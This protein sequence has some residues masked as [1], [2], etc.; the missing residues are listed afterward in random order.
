MRKALLMFSCFLLFSSI[1]NPTR[2]QWQSQTILSEKMQY[3]SLAAPASK[4]FVHFDKTIYTN[5]ETVWFSA[6]FLKLKPQKAM[7]HELLCVALVRD[8]DSA[9]IKQEKYIAGS[10]MAFGS[11]VLP[12]SMLTGNYHFQVTTN[13][14]SKGV[15]ELSFIQPVLIKTNIDPSFN[16]SIKLLQPAGP[17]AEPNK[18]LISVLSRDARFLP[19]AGRHQL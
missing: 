14:V 18:V 10:G 9:I 2:A 12:D 17:G 19:K 11:M 5:N 3:H 16:A 13:L 6:Y 7:M 8:I 1:F 4:I 15:P